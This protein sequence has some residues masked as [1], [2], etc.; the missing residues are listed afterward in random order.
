MTISAFREVDL[1]AD[2]GVAALGAVPGFRVT[3]RADQSCQALHAVYVAQAW[4]PIA[5][6][7]ELLSPDP[8]QQQ[9]FRQR[10]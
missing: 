6:V 7:D 1:V 3:G 4:L 5:I 8:L 2:A 10:P 9:H